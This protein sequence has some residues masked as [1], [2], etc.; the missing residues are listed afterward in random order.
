LWFLVTPHLPPTAPLF[1]YSTLFRSSSG[2]L[3]PAADVPIAFVDLQAESIGDDV[4]PTAEAL[5]LFEARSG[6]LD[7][8]VLKECK[9]LR[10]RPQD[11][12]STRLNSSHEWNSYAVFC[13]KK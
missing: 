2:D 8:R 10:S 12:K 5:A 4:W 1:P 6:L 13:L 7:H 3:A 11:R 9:R